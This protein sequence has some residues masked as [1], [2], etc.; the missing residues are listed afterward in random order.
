VTAAVLAGVLL[1]DAPDRDGSL[2]EGVRAPVPDVTSGRAA[3]TGSSSPQ[4]SRT[5]PSS[6]ASG[7]PSPSPSPASKAPSPSAV[8][9]SA[10]S[11]GATGT[12]SPGPSATN[13]TPTVLRLGDS[14][15]EVVEL[16]LRLRQIG[17]YGGEADGEYSRQVESAVRTYQLTRAVLQ[18]ESGVYGAATRASLEAETDEP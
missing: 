15:P 11:T 16:Q 1:Y 13:S 5:Q 7:S 6:T 4:A 17:F 9:P 12:A 8:P 3:T 2:A 10:P 14:G 18:D